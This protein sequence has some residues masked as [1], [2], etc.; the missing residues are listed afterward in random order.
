MY[1]I[2]LLSIIRSCFLGQLYNMNMN[3]TFPHHLS[4]IVFTDN[5]PEIAFRT[6]KI[7]K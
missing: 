6:S 7:H 4:F 3:I 5:G 1:M 2:K